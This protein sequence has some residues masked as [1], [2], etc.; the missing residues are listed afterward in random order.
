[1]EHSLIGSSLQ[2]TH[3]LKNSFKEHISSIFFQSNLAS[4]NLFGGFD[5]K[6]NSS[7]TRVKKSLKPTKNVTFY[8]ISIANNAISSNI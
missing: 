4:W 2:E 8:K 1:M 7:G 3:F 6:R 5:A